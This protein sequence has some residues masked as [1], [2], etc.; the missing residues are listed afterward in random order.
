MKDSDTQSSS[1]TAATAHA[2]WH[3]HSKA[4]MPSTAAARH[5]CS[6][7]GTA[8]ANRTIH[9]EPLRTQK[10]TL[11]TDVSVALVVGVIETISKELMKKIL[12]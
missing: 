5:L 1:R 9:A 2:R 3:K 11:L 6:T 10:R 4:T 7:A 12:T 8:A